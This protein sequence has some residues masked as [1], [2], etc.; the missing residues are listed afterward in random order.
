MIGRS[1]TKTEKVRKPP[2]EM[3]LFEH[4]DELR[5][6]LV[7]AIIGLVIGM[8]LGTFLTE[9]VLRILIAPLGDL[10]PVALSPT[11]TPSVFFKLA[12]L[13]GMII[14]MPVIVYQLF[15]FAAPGMRPEERRYVFIGAPIASLSFAAGVV[16]AA[17]VILPAA[18]PFLKGFLGDIVEPTYSIDKYIGFVG[19]ILLWAGLVFETPL[20]MYFLA[21]LGVVTPEGFGKARRIVIVAAAVG[22]AVIT[23]TLDPV[24]MMALMVPFILLYELGILLAKLARRRRR[25]EMA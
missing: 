8:V 12:L 3:T 4:L 23:P 24:N 19:N 25:R 15:Q 10:S 2:D 13:I 11:E 6:R 20:I 9:P 17:M 7:K 18:V 14:A 21:I 1:K 22:A 5:Q 16:F